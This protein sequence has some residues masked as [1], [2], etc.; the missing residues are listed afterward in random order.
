VEEEEAWQREQALHMADFLEAGQF[1]PPYTL[2]K[3]PADLYRQQ[4]APL[5]KATPSTLVFEANKWQA[6]NRLVPEP[7]ERVIQRLPAEAYVGPEGPRGGPLGNPGEPVWF[8]MNHRLQAILK[9][10]G[11]RAERRR[12][13]RLRSKLLTGR[14]AKG[15]GK[16]S[17]GRSLREYFDKAALERAEGQAGLPGVASGEF[18]GKVHE[19]YLQRRERFEQQRFQV[20]G[21]AR[22]LAI[23]EEPPPR[24]GRVVRPVY[25][26]PPGM[27]TERLH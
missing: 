7:F 9:K 16:K 6:C 17:E 26:P 12:K 22:D 13:R 25:C 5:M 10:Q 21:T 24:V 3:S 8:E 11:R 14:A 1:L 19:Q 15:G 27:R 18:L 4:V 2:P 23:G 20:R